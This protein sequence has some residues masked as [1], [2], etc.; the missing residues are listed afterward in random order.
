M[1]PF[2]SVSTELNGILR[3]FSDCLAADLGNLLYKGE[4]QNQPNVKI[5]R[6]G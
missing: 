1:K 2:H 5:R 6:S 4:G 3:R